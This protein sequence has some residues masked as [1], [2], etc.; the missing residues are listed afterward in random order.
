MDLSKA[1]CDG[2]PEFPLSYRVAQHFSTCSNTSIMCVKLP[3]HN[4]VKFFSSGVGL[5]GCFPPLVKGSYHILVTVREPSELAMSS[6]LL[7][8]AIGFQGRTCSSLIVPDYTVE[9][10]LFGCRFFDDVNC[11]PKS[12]GPRAWGIFHCRFCGGKFL[13]ALLVSKQLWCLEFPLGCEVGFFLFEHVFPRG[14]LKFRHRLHC[15]QGSWGSWGW[16]WLGWCML[17][18]Q[19]CKNS[20]L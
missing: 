1:I 13:V 5:R 17:D 16:C 11:E 8:S 12:L 14:F 20:E 10:L 7:S 9:G 18:E 15:F 3:K 6:C 19:C 4:G 2:S